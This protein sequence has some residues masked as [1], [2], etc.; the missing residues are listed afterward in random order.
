[1]VGYVFKVNSVLP[2]VNEAV[3]RKVC[4]V[5]VVNVVVRR[6]W[7]MFFDKTLN[8][9]VIKISWTEDEDNVNF[10]STTYT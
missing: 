8:I 10:V 5:A 4:A 9:M 3:D 2:L 1:M 6:S 7:N